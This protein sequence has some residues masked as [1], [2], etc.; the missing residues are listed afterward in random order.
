MMNVISCYL[1]EE[2]Y[3]TVVIPRSAHR[4]ACYYADG[5]SQ[6]LVSPGA[7]DMAGLVI[8]PRESDFGRITADEVAA[9]LSEV[10]MS[11]EQADEVAGKI[12]GMA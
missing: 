8:T 5:D 9:M 4:P 2:G 7:L 10:A 12:R 11:R 1:R 6:I 3:V